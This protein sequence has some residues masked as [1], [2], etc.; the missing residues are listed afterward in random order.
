MNGGK[1]GRDV[2]V[3][4]MLRNNTDLEIRRGYICLEMSMERVLM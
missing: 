4:D 3:E 2:D 1:G